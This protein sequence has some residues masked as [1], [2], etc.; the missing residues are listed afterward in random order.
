M[1]CCKVDRVAIHNRIGLS[2]TVLRRLVHANRTKILHA[3]R[4]DL[5]QVHE[6]LV[7]IVMSGI[8]P[9][10]SVGR[11]TAEFLLRRTLVGHCGFLAAGARGQK[12]GKHDVG[13]SSESTSDIPA[14]A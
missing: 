8:E 13:S 10:S 1:L 3:L 9:A 14:F 7:A 11:R 5:F 6:L 2:C 4:I 12:Y